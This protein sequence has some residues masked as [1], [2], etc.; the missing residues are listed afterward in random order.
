MDP[1]QRKLLEYTYKALENG[2]RGAQLILPGVANIKKL[3]S[4][5]ASGVL[6]WFEDV[7]LYW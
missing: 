4:W 3:N 2:R 5:Y 6:Y 7:R 1:Q